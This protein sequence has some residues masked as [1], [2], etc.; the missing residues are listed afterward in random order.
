MSNTTQKITLKKLVELHNAGGVMD[1][2]MFV[3]TDS[4]WAEYMTRFDLSDPIMV[5]LTNAWR[6]H[7]TAKFALMD[8]F[9]QASEAVGLPE[10]N[11]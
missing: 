10:A 9:K 1:A 3:P 4:S 2:P 5:D 11:F 8:A 6:A 7:M